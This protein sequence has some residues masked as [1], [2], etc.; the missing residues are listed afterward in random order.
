MI[1]MRDFWLQAR[2]T[3]G[4]CKLKEF[5]DYKVGY[6]VQGAAGKKE[7]GPRAALKTPV[8]G[9]QGAPHPVRSL[10]E[11]MC[12]PCFPSWGFCAEES[13]ALGEGLGELC[14]HSTARCR[15]G[16]EIRALIRRKGSKCPTT[17]SP[18]QMP[19]NCIWHKCFNT[20]ALS[21]FVRFPVHWKG[22]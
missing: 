14:S 22:M 15:R 8:S 16:K 2:E 3:S 6:R 10:E 4:Q 5:E 11:A 17:K 9:A 18:L 19:P 1:S 12:L 21:G 13:E 20:T 7:A